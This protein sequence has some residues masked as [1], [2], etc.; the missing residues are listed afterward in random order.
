MGNYLPNG[1]GERAPLSKELAPFEVHAEQFIHTSEDIEE[2]VHLEGRPNVD[3]VDLTKDSDLPENQ[4]RLLLSRDALADTMVKLAEENG[5]VDV[6][7]KD[8]IKETAKDYLQK[9]T[10]RKYLD[11]LYRDARNGNIEGVAGHLKEI[12]GRIWEAFNH[13]HGI[14]VKAGSTGEGVQKPIKETRRRAQ[15]AMEDP[16]RVSA[17]RWP[18][19]HVETRRLGFSQVTPE[20][21]ERSA[22]EGGGSVRPAWGNKRHKAVGGPGPDD[23]EFGRTGTDK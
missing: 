4:D 9:R 12:F 1:P 15:A 6:A 13:L 2:A 14:E 3:T 5:V 21:F 17:I 8:W 11:A 7:K 10:V 22:M 19:L 18:D 20:G 23:L 16:G